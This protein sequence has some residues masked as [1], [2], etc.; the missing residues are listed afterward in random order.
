MQNLKGT[1]VV[2]T[3][4]YSYDAAGNQT[5][6][7]EVLQGV[8][9]G[10]TT[11]AYDALNRL[12]TVVEPSGKSTTY[13]YDGAGNRTQQ[14]VKSGTTAAIT[15]YAYNE[16]N[17]LVSEELINSLTDKTV[18]QYR[19]DNNGNTLA[20]SKETTK[21][22]NPLSPPMPTFGI[23]VEGQSNDNSRIQDIVASAASYE[24]DVWNQMVKTTTSSGTSVYG[25]NEEGYRTSKTIN[26]K[27]T[28]Y[29][30]EDNHVVL[31]TDGSG[32]QTALNMYGVNLLTRAVGTDKFTYLYNGH[33]D[34]TALADAAGTIKGTYYYDSW[35]NLLDKT[36]TVDNPIRYAGYQ[37]DEESGLY[38]LNARYYNPA[39]ARFMSEDSVDGEE[40]DP[41]SLNLYTYVKNEPIMYDD[42]TGH[43]FNMIVGAIVG[44]AMTAVTDVVVNVAKRGMNTKDWQ[45]SS[46]KTYAMAAIEGALTSGMSAVYARAGGMAAKAAASYATKA[47]TKTVTRAASSAAKSVAKSAAKA[48]TTAA[49][50]AARS[51]A[52]ASSSTAKTVSKA[53]KAA[54]K[55]VAKAS[56]TTAKSVTK[57]TKTVAQKVTQKVSKPVS[58]PKATNAIK[59][60]EKELTQTTGSNGTKINLKKPEKPKV[61]KAKKPGGYEVSDVDEHGLLSPGKN[62]APGNG[63]TKADDFVQSHHPIQDE[64]AKRN[65]VNYNSKDAPAVLLKSS[66]GNAHALISA[67]QRQRRAIEG[68]GKDIKYEFN[69]SYKEM[70]N[71][72]VS[73]KVARNAIGKSYKYFDSI[74]AFSK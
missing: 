30:Y 51:V 72:G 70:I 50:S 44:V 61:G 54:A 38:Y 41:L 13:T 71:A 62:R 40:N 46:V 1:T 31:E 37:Y 68:F 53:S 15:A 67:A 28:L 45:M 3:Y 52:K 16:Q 66:S 47:A 21:N 60:S 6:K 35:G 18:T 14:V 4:T 12:Q 22:Y 63:N 5:Y 2:D 36:G 26:G 69:T 58:K 43:F 56:S 57:T 29:L 8:T 42:P 25:Y 24:Y 11:Y 33:A 10:T 39:N 64:W 34:V 32:K 17:R 55:T 74:G 59:S 48:S 9:K 19:Y 49:K 7:Y 73:T 27:T 65:V 23:Y 20:V